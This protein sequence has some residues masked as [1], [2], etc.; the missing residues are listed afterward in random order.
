MTLNGLLD[1][2][3]NG[4][5]QFA[6]DFAKGVR[7]ANTGDP[8]AIA[9]VESWFDPPRPNYGIIVFINLGGVV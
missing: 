3:D 1:K 8:A 9:W 6:T 5:V 7:D 2:I 4:T